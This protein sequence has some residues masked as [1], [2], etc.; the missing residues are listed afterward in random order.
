MDDVPNINQI[1]PL[2]PKRPDE[3][4]GDQQQQG[5]QGKKRKPE[6]EENNKPPKS[7]HDG[8]IDEYV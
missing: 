5:G 8:Q 6:V 7:D 1:K 4:T 2:W 3:K